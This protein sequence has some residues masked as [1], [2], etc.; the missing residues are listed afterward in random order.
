MSLYDSYNTLLLKS[1]MTFEDVFLHDK[2]IRKFIKNKYHAREKSKAFEVATKEF[3]L[4]KRG[5][6]E[7]SAYFL[8]CV[9]SNIVWYSLEEF[10]KNNPKNVI[11][12]I[13]IWHNIC[14][15]NRIYTTYKDMCQK[16]LKRTKIVLACGG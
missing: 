6:H 14:L 3:D 4:F 2:D 16:I 10:I 9:L 15:C 11:D 7:V 12:I 13:K 1:S 8:G 5:R